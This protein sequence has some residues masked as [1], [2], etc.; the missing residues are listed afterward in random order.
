VIIELWM[1]KGFNNLLKDN[2]DSVYEINEKNRNS[3]FKLDIYNGTV[4]N[5]KDYNC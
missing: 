5:K 3:R 1:D 4:K 2:I